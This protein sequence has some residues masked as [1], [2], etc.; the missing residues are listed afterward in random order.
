M[1]KWT[2]ADSEGF[3]KKLLKRRFG[4]KSER[5]KQVKGK[6]VPVLN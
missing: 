1:Q 4:L 5:G 3:V 6:V 2:W